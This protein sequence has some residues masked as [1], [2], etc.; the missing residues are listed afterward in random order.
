MKKGVLQ[1]ISNELLKTRWLTFPWFDT[2]VWHVHIDNA[3]SVIVL[4]QQIIIVI[5]MINRPCKRLSFDVIALYVKKT[6]SLRCI[7][8]P[9]CGWDS[10]FETKTIGRDKDIT[11]YGSKQT[12]KSK[13]SK[14]PTLGFVYRFID[15]NLPTRAILFISLSSLL[16]LFPLN[17]VA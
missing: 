13:S 9:T 3:I 6:L 16:I 7:M 2:H 8:P 14:Q 5:T 10:S 12:G 1:T 17:F 15:F 11:S 4:L